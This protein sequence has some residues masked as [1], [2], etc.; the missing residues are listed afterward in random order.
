MKLGIVTFH[1]AVNYGA[2]LQC[3]A[4]KKTLES[5]GHDVYLVDVTL[6]QKKGSLKSKI[7]KIFFEYKSFRNF[8]QKHLPTILRD[9]DLP[10]LDFIIYG[11]DQ[12]WNV[13]ITN[14]NY[15]C[16]F[17]GGKL[18]N[19]K[20]I[21]YA[22]SFG[23]SHW[24]HDSITCN[25]RE[26]LYKYQAIG[27][28]ETSGKD[29]LKEVFDTESTVVI[30]PTMLLAANQYESLCSPTEVSTTGV[31]A[32]IFEKNKKKIS[33]LSNLASQLSLNLTILNHTYCK[34]KNVQAVPF[35]SV[36]N[37]LSDIKGSEYVITDSFH[38]MV[39]SILFRK[40]FIA[41]PAVPERAGRMKSLLSQL[42]LES[43]FFDNLEL[44]DGKIGLLPKIDYDDVDE[45]LD[46]IKFNSLSFL[47]EALSD[48]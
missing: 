21:A 40:E 37:W 31:V 24:K 48:D 38:C 16:Y 25:V 8:N 41:I 36:T 26:L 15:E 19:I 20:K 39:F 13:D 47:K 35:P 6:P 3:Y 28:R 30:D 10:T 14:E 11:S 34:V 5:L 22:A 44:V 4:M 18:K 2:V 32:Y 42:G 46:I 45:K 17:G 7:R 23:V 12:I 43:R 29:M 1:Q 9:S 33:L 27:I